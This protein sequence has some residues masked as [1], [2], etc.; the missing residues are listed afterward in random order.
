MAKLDVTDIPVKPEEAIAFFRAKG[1]RLEESFDW[2]DV[3]ARAHA[4]SFTVA[5]STG[6]DIL[7]DIHDALDAAIAEGKTLRQFSDELTPV[8]QAKGWWGKREREDPATGESK[9]VQLGSPRRLRVIFNT[10]LSMAYMAGKWQRMMRLAERRPWLRYVSVQDD[11]VRRTHRSWHGTIL[12]WDHPWWTK[13]Y[14]PNDF[15]CRC[16]VQQLSDR[17]LERLKLAPSP[18]VPT[19]LERSYVNPRTG[20][21]SRVPDGIKPGFDHNVGQLA[22]EAHAGKR[23]MDRIS[24]MP[25]AMAAQAFQSSLSFA[26]S[27]VAYEFQGWLRAALALGLQ[28]GTSRIIASL[29]PAAVVALGADAPA[30]LRVADGVASTM[31][32]QLALRLPLLASRPMAL[33]RDAQGRLLLVVEAV[34]DAEMQC[35]TLAAD[36]TITHALIA[37]RADLAR[38]TLLWGTL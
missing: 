29:P 13:H 22:R 35:L 19:L 33:L 34:G 11:R 2:R 7:K 23:L 31:A 10:N 14:P 37:R 25:P 1:F 12:R 38:E 27:G 8:L 36:G 4:E 9:L 5:K 21:Q 17:D 3:S 16:D 28:A 20:E 32:E 26:Q 6:F 18:T 15:G 30:V 24:T